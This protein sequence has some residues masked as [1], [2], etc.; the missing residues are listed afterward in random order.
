MRK[1]GHIFFLAGALIAASSLSLQAQEIRGAAGECTRLVLDGDRPLLLLH[2]DSLGNTLSLKAYSYQGTLS[3]DVT[4]YRSEKDWKRVSYE[5]R[6]GELASVAVH[7]PSG[8]VD[9]VWVRRRDF[10]QEGSWAK[11]KA[12]PQV[13]DPLAEWQ[14]AQEGARICEADPLLHPDPLDGGA[15]LFSADGRFLCRVHSEYP[16]GPLLKWRREGEE[17]IR[18]RFADPVADPLAVGLQSRAIHVETEYVQRA[19]QLCE[20]GKARNRGF[21]K[22]ML[23]LARNSGYGSTL[24]FAVREEYNIS[25]EVFYI[26]ETAPEGIL[27]HNHFNFG[28]YLWGASAREAAVPLWLARLGAHINNFFLS[29]D[30]CGTWDSPDDQLSISAGYHWQ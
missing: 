20:A 12:L 5:Y 21:F 23:F 15:F 8:K 4:H 14:R 11:Y 10:A 27:A 13:P 1:R 24:D 6:A 22:G 7:T 19:M 17:P 2:L 25:P 3:R 29:P 18:A 16:D 9:S 26:T 28:N 30:S